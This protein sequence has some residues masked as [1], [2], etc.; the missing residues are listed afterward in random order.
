MIVTLWPFAEA[1]RPGAVDDLSWSEFCEEVSELAQQVT[2]APKSADPEVQKK[3]LPGIGPHRLAEGEERRLLANVEAVTLGVLDVDDGADPDKIISRLKKAGHAALI[4]ASPRD[5]PKHRKLRV[6][7]PLTRELTPG[8][9]PEFRQRLAEVVGIGPGQG[10]EG[11]IDA[12]KLFFVG[13]LH[14]TPPRDV[15]R[16]PG[17]PVNPDRLPPTR[18]DWRAGKAKPA[19][20]GPL[21]QLPPAT[22]GIA[23]ALGPWADHEGHRWELCGAVGGLMRRLGYSA[24]QCE[25]EIRAWLPAKDKAVN[26]EHGLKW[27]LGAW[28]KD[29]GEVSGAETLAGIVGEEHARVIESAARSGSSTHRAL[30]KIRATAKP[31]LARIV[32]SAAE[33]D[34][35][36]GPKF[37]W[38]GPLPKI[39]YYCEGLRLAPSRGKISV[40]GGLPGAGKGPFAN[41][42]ALCFALGLK[43]FDRWHCEQKRVTLLDCE[44]LLLTAER[45]ARMT[46]AVRRK[47]AEL[48]E[49]LDL[50]DVSG[51]QLF[52]P[53]FFERLEETEPEVVILDSYTSA[54]MTTDEEPN[55]PAYAKLARCFGQLGCLVIAVTHARKIPVDQRP[56]LGDIAGS[57]ALG[58]LAQTGI[59]ARRP[60]PENRTLIRFECMRAPRDQFAPFD[61]TFNDTKWGGLLLEAEDAATTAEAKAEARGESLSVMANRVLVAMHKAPATP[62]S[63][64]ELSERV[65]GNRAAAYDAVA[66]LE[67]ADFLECQPGARG[68]VY[69]LT[70]DAPKSVTVRG[71]EVESAGRGAG[72]SVG[73]FRKRPGNDGRGE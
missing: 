69:V 1:K 66:A 4:Y 10:V 45:I 42:L 15:W 5:T 49:A 7:V 53:G 13:R 27:A 9:C 29:A 63:R 24:A 26:V 52:T 48:Q 56:E 72:G 51:L 18:R 6:I 58:A 21:A 71:G 36:L 44:G 47:P 55:S 17:K 14:G 34:D 40:V 31:A 12:A 41:Y 37:D 20:A 64:R 8:E 59:S 22:A 73:R 28:A 57:G 54:M 3:A 23:A 16:V 65:G 32:A 50:H 33:S 11:A 68:A 19:P 39:E 43:A 60:D 62:M 25:A 35:P 30:E 67:R 38:T 61:V 46:K 70:S 2:P